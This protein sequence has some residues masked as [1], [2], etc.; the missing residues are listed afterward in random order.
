MEDEPLIRQLIV[1]N[2]KSLGCEVTPTCEGAETVARYQESVHQGQPFDLLVM[3][4]SIPGG[5]GGAAAMEKIRQIDPGVRAIVSS[6]YS[7]DPVMSRYLD[8]GFRAVLPKPY[9]PQELRELV[10]E[11]LQ[12]GR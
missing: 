4:L 2:L 7:D 3:D 1:H 9:Q 8:Y 6:G 12:E 11:L 10:E 5:M